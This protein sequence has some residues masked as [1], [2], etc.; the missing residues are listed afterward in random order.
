M[1]AL[2]L[3]LLCW[4]VGWLDGWV[5]GCLVGWLGGGLVDWLAGSLVGWLAER[6]LRHRRRVIRVDW[7]SRFRR[8]HPSQ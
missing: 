1:C 4:I 5:V 2:L 6:A 8:E 7:G 3:L